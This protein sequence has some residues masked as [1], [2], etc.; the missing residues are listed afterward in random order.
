M[1]AVLT[2]GHALTRVDTGLA[3][4]ALSGLRA[5]PR[6]AV[7]DFARGT[8]DLPLRLRRY[9]LEVI[10]PDALARWL[11]GEAPPGATGEVD[12]TPWLATLALSPTPVDPSD[13]LALASQLGLSHPA[14]HLAAVEGD[15]RHVGARLSWPW[16]ARAARLEWLLRQEDLFGLAREFWRL[17]HLPGAADTAVDRA[18]AV[19]QAWLDLFTDPD[20][21]APLLY[22]EPSR[23]AWIEEALAGLDVADAAPRPGVLRLGWTW[24]DVQPMTRVLLLARG[25]G[26]QVVEPKPSRRRWIATAAC[27]AA[28]VVGV[29]GF[30]RPLS[31]DEPAISEEGPRP[32]WADEPTIEAL[33]DGTYRVEIALLQ[34]LRPMVEA[35]A[36]ATVHVDWAG[37]Q[38]PC[39]QVDGELE[40][41]FCAEGPPPGGE[42][43]RGER[44]II[45]ADG[46]ENLDASRLARAL[47]E[48]G[49][50]DEVIFA[51][52]RPQT[53][54]H[55]GTEEYEVALLQRFYWRIDP[56]AAPEKA[57]RFAAEVRGQP[58]AALTARLGGT[59]WRPAAEV[60]PQI[61]G[62]NPL[63]DKLKGSVDPGLRYERFVVEPDGAL[64]VWLAGGTGVPAIAD[65][66]YD[67][68]TRQ[69]WVVLAG[70][71]VA[72]D[73]PGWPVVLPA[74]TGFN[75]IGVGEDPRGGRI[76][77]ELAEAA[78][79]PYGTISVLREVEGRSTPTPG[80]LVLRFPPGQVSRPYDVGVVRGTCPEGKRLVTVAEARAYLGLLCPKVALY[81]ADLAD[82]WVLASADG[83]CRLDRASGKGVRWSLCAAGEAAPKAS[84]VSLEVEVDPATPLRPA[85]VKIP[86]GTFTMGSPP[87]EA[88]RQD[89]ETPHPVTLMAGFAMMQ[90]EVTQ[91]QWWALMGSYPSRFRA[92]GGTCPVEQVTWLDAVGYAN[93]LSKKEVLPV[94]YQMEPAVHVVPG[95]TGYRLPTEAEWEYAA[96][97]GT[98]GRAYGDAADIAW[99]RENSG[100]TTHPVAQKQPNAWGLYDMLGNVFEFTGDWYAAP[101]D[102]QSGPDPA[103]PPSGQFRVMRGGAWNSVARGIRAAD[104]DGWRPGD[105]H[106]GVGFRLVR[107]EAARQQN[108]LPGASYVTLE[109]MTGDDLRVA[110]FLG[111]ADPAAVRIEASGVTKSGVW[112]TLGG[113]GTPA[114]WSQEDRDVRA[115]SADEGVRLEMDLPTPP[116]RKLLDWVVPHVDGKQVSI[117]VLGG[118][119]AKSLVTMFDGV[120]LRVKTRIGEVQKQGRQVDQG[121]V[122]REQRKLESL[123]DT[124][125]RRAS[126]AGSLS[127]EA[128]GRSLADLDP[129]AI[130][131]CFS[132]LKGPAADLD[133]LDELRR[134][135]RDVF[136]LAAEVQ[137]NE[138][139]ACISKPY[140]ELVALIEN[141]EAIIARGAR[142]DQP[143]LQR[144]ISLR[145]QAEVCLKAPAG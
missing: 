58:Y 39:R 54:Y 99:F 110:T 129:F 115:R 43:E 63:K 25:F 113:L 73:E 136:R 142:L 33:D 48:T 121:C 137:S 62:R 100:D 116:P 85:L 104:R 55:G 42:G 128:L 87:D 139:R 72:R 14:R 18:R 112:F 49:N 41:W 66:G 78:A 114:G 84:E 134:T 74:D 135:A 17:R 105:R 5:W 83:K 16:S 109:V 132:A 67:P 64:R 26:G 19:E 79:L 141:T 130:E 71:R 12:L 60:W 56:G 95:C 89:D 30:A 34:H 131:Q 52:T 81:P 35:P 57:S 92:C 65:Q 1:V 108:A 9:G 82:G 59:E 24:A 45:L 120:A 93:A 4:V 20:A 106:P 40:R 102:V 111:V 144:Q 11:G 3:A 51:P 125:L 80:A 117:A 96:R 122:V 118:D 107:R 68:K 140:M 44:H 145:Y 90:T 23:R 69:A 21:A 97:A 103:G 2:D 94:C 36:G 124:T 50:A 86:P 76:E 37:S 143:L 46:A 53:G 27:A 15:A 91:A 126:A 123:L 77:V 75:S 138:A 101:Y 28:A 38:A 70:A 119:L 13:A 61:E 47:L 7:V 88:G 6:L 8:T 10:E 31:H 98:S 29:V 32:A 127:Q 133:R 22:A